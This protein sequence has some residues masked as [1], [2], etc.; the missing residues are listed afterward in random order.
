MVLPLDS[1][2]WPSQGTSSTSPVSSSSFFPG[3]QSRVLTIWPKICLH[4]IENWIFLTLF[5]TINNF[6]LYSTIIRSA[7]C[8]WT[9]FWPSGRYVYLTITIWY[10]IVCK[11]FCFA[12]TYF[13]QTIKLWAWFSF[14]FGIDQNLSQFRNRY[15]SG[16]YSTIDKDS[17]ADLGVIF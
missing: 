7:A 2:P 10:R 5:V 6:T 9:P 11:S 13:Y 15:Y 4:I 8:P 1:D 16:N 3:V 12:I 14:M 17:N